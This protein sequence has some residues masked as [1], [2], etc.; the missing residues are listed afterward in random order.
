MKWLITCHISSYFVFYLFL[1]CSHV[2]C[3]KKPF[4]SWVVWSWLPTET[5]LCS[6][7]RW[8]W[9]V[10]QFYLRSQDAKMPP[11]QHHLVCGYCYQTSCAGGR[12]NM[13]PPP[14][15]WP[16]TLKVVSE[17]CVTLATSVPILVF[18]GLS[19][20]NLGPIY[21]TGRRQTCIIA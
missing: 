8:L 2:L 15:S 9:K 6:C 19:V 14:A 18:Q 13:P 3:L 7:Y 1:K 21:V 20:L 17:S 16:L 12:H 4:Q 10:V 5:R 11:E